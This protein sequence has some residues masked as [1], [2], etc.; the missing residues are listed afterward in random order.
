MDTHNPFLQNSNTPLDYDAVT[1]DNMRAAFDYVLQAHDQGIARII[2]AQQALPTWDDFVLAVD[3][4]DAQLLGVFNAAL[5][6]LGK[7]QNWDNA[8]FGFYGKVFERF[9]QKLADSRLQALYERLAKSANGVNLDAQKRATLQWYL[10]K[11]A[12]SGTSLD[13]DGK[14]HL[15]ELQKQ[16][17]TLRGRYQ[18][19]LDHPALAITDEAELRGIPQRVRD[20]LA[21][22]AQEAGE[23]GWL[24]ASET[25]V[26]D[27]VLM[28][29]EHRPLRERVYRAYHLRGVSE[30]HQQ[31]NGTHLQRLAEL[32]DEKARLLGFANHAELSLQ[33][34]SAGAPTVVNK[35]LH[36]LANSLRPAMTQRRSQIESQAAEQ[37]LS[38]LEPWDISYLQEQARASTNVLSTESLREFFPLS[39]VVSALTRLADKLFGLALV[40]KPFATWDESVLTFEAWQDN[41]LIGFLYLDAV[42][43]PG[44]QPDMISTTY[45]RNRRV[46]AE[47]IYQKA[48]VVVFSDIPAAVDGGQPLLDHMSL[49]KLY[50][51]FGHALHHLLVRTTNFVLSSVTELGTDGVELFG[52][53]FERWVWDAGYLVE[54]SSHHRKGSKLTQERV[55]E[56]LGR[57]RQD[58]LEEATR[59]LSLALFDLDLHTTPND[60]RNIEQ[61]LTEARERCGYWPLADFEHPVHA[62][63]H[64]VSGYDAG[65]Y[66]YLWADVHA[67]DLFT[68]FEAQGLL[69]HDTGR[70]LQDALFAPGA[71][72]SLREGIEAFLGRSPSQVPYLRWHGVN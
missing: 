51:E 71:S 39:A 20:E 4:L 62:F 67:F 38:S 9:D 46:N 42:Q 61:R 3:E 22:R 44:K 37:G 65:Y 14:A 41:A 58:G 30:D 34:K 63:P 59:D 43:H 54:I 68:R 13:A 16:I 57:L 27:A 24:I 10:D 45:L 69:D 8:I 17:T 19:N 25:A 55:E 26:T 21:S 47:G 29:A 11:F 53:L 60:G 15:A 23:Q 66:A 35:Y 12:A 56:C 52:K 70:A 28:Y 18:G 40:A 2:D 64:L 72:R 50:H 49:R 48:A 32:L 31:D 36:D 5:P 33:A 6:L 7:G 1:L